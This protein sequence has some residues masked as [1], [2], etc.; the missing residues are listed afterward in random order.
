MTLKQDTATRRSPAAKSRASAKAVA[1]G[2]TSPLLEN[3]SKHLSGSGGRFASVAPGRLDVMG[4]L[5]DYTGA[6]VLGIPLE[7]HAC[8]AMQRRTDGVVSVVAGAGAAKNGDV[9]VEIPVEKLCPPSGTVL[10]AAS[11]LKLLGKK[12]STDAVCCVG[13]LV[14]A[15]RAGLLPS[16]SGGLS[17]AV[18]TTLAKLSGAGRHG[19]V[20]AAAIAAASSVLD[21][22]IDAV[23]AAHACSEVEN[24]WFGRAVGVSGAACSLSGQAGLIN[25][26]RCDPCNLS[27]TVAIPD[28]VSLVGIH[29]GATRDDAWEKFDQVRTA[30]FMGRAVVDRIVKHE[31]L[32]QIRWDGYLSRISINDYVER[33]RDRLPTKIKGRDY[34]DRLGDP[35]D[36]LTTVDAGFSYKV[37]SRTEHHIYE[38]ARSCQFVEC[39]NRAARSSDDRALLDAGEL[40]YASHWSYGQRCGLGSVAAD[41]LLNCF[42]V[43]GAE[44]D[45]FGAKVTAE[46]CGGVVLVLMKSTEKANVAFQRAIDAYGEKSGETP[47][48]L[49]GSTC[50][51][52]VGGTVAV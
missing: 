2:V 9:A 23:G 38:H 12:C 34:L 35:G 28:G 5:A 27:G 30:T 14:E 33:F 11:C 1:R 20:C 40:M 36:A 29:C 39:M 22:T 13:A 26:V 10:D 46:G 17:V 25:E 7:R 32:D 43:Q 6:L 37:R 44:A 50:G 31:R 19:A 45:V 49:R 18:D 15:L 24:V 4:S 16:F 42:R 48:V 21:V 51:A 52:L 41:S 3:V 8:V 47:T